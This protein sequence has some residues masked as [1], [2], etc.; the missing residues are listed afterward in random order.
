M[1]S[2]CCFGLGDF[3]SSCMHVSSVWRVCVCVV[4]ADSLTSVVVLIGALAL[5]VV[6]YN[7]V[8]APQPAV[9]YIRRRSP[10]S[11]IYGALALRRAGGQKATSPSNIRLGGRRWAVRIE[12]GGVKVLAACSLDIGIAPR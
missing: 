7:V 8:P 4:P 10:P 3:F 9:A 6:P 11:H 5:L 1:L 2:V 12:V